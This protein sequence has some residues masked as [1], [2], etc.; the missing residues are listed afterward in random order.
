MKFDW[1]L[2]SYLM[3]GVGRSLPARRPVC[4]FSTGRVPS[5]RGGG[6]AWAG[7]FWDPWNVTG[8]YVDL[9]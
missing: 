5:R 8:Y 7:H 3:V 2:S 4:S 6:L 1:A 9:P